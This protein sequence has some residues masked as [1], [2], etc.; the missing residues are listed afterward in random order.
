MGLS[1]SVPLSWSLA[2]EGAASGTAA[3]RGRGRWEAEEAL[4]G[5]CT[6][7]FLLLDPL[8]LCSTLTDPA[9][10]ASSGLAALPMSVRVSPLP[11]CWLPPCSSPSPSVKLLKT[12]GGMMIPSGRSPTGWKPIMSAPYS[13]T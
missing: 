12:G 5:A 9:L 4:E 8:A 11:P 10:S 3:G 1:S 6:A 7:A 13:I 2:L